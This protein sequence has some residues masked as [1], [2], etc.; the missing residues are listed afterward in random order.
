MMA[1]NFRRRTLGAAIFALGILGAGIA[2]AEPQHGIAMYGEPA[3]PPDFDHLPYTNPDAPEGGRLVM[4]ETGGFDSLNPH[5]LKGTVPWQL[6]FLAY[7]SLMG[8]SWDEPF[9]LYGLL[10]E[11]VGRDGARMPKPTSR[12]QSAASLHGKQSA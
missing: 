4:G 5:I 8:R 10:A 12:S 3:L 7:E 9:T 11:A 6:R 1:D 2:S